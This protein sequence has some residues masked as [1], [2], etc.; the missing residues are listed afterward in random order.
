MASFTLKATPFPDSTV[1]K[2]YD[3]TLYD[4]FPPSGPP[5]TAVASAT[6]TA[7]TVAFTGLVAG[8][9]YFAAA[10]VEGVWRNRTFITEVPEGGT[11]EQGPQ[12]E[13]GPAG[14]DGRDGTNWES[15]EGAPTN[16]V[17]NPGDFYFDLE[18]ARIYGPKSG[19]NPG[20][21]P[22]KYIPLT[23]DKEAEEEVPPEEEEAPPR[24]F[25]ADSY[26]NHV[27]GSSPPLDASSATLVS[28][29]VGAVGSTPWINYSSGGVA[30]YEV[31]ENQTTKKVTI[32]T[33]ETNDPNLQAACNA[34][35]LPENPVAAAG[36]DKHLVV[37]QP[38]KDRIWEFWNFRKEGSEYK[39]G[40]A[41][42]L[43]HASESLGT[44]GVG[45]SPDA[46][47]F[48]GGRAS[49]IP[50]VAGI[51]TS[52]D[53]E[54]GAIPHALAMS[55][56]STINRNTYRWPAQHTDGGQTSTSY[57]QEGMLFR[58]KPSYNIGASGKSACVKMLMT[59]VQ[60]YGLMVVDQGPD[61]SLYG[62]DP[63]THGKTALWTS[64]LE[65]KEPSEQLKNFP[66]S[67]LQVVNLEALFEERGLI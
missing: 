21:W 5:G 13:Q 1:V 46:K 29:L 26:F 23:V 52:E 22:A 51:I 65:G 20:V 56:P 16:T 45:S 42:F 19:T 33:S 47:G 67:E 9:R 24:F 27:L 59:A 53:L 50:V 66:W 63:A 11:G 39:A 48:W 8:T 12:G 32:P 2:A 18:N 25:S 7:G 38:S 61:L 64:F 54:R 49:A 17:G 34:V 43:E 6:A 4:S 30:I 14:E 31:P 10:L 35:P 57:L 62:E 3:A 55:I 60:E 40:N 44:M 37:Y 41:G 28:T 36:S 15:G 58:L